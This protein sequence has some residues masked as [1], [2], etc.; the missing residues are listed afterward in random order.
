MPLVPVSGICS[1]KRDR[2]REAVN[3]Q[4]NWCISMDQFQQWAEVEKHSDLEN[5]QMVLQLLPYH[6]GNLA[7]ELAQTPV[8]NNDSVP[9]Q[10]VTLDV[11]TT[12][13]RG[14]PTLQNSP[15]YHASIHQ[16]QQL[17]QQG[18]MVQLIVNFQGQHTIEPTLANEFYNRLRQLF[19]D[20]AEVE[21]RSA[22]QDRQMLIQLISSLKTVVNLTSHED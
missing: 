16:A 1:R 17:L 8:T 5:G 7:S 12:R 18:Y 6:Q 10:P 14:N 21:Q 2:F 19:Q 13:F 9:E 22:L 15:N 4:L 11:I 3:L 20:W